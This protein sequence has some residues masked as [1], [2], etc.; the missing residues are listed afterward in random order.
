MF[1]SVPAAIKFVRF[2]CQSAGHCLTNFMYSDICNNQNDFQPCTPRMTERRVWGTKISGYQNNSNNQ[3]FIHSWWLGISSAVP[4]IPLH[5]YRHFKTLHYKDVKN[6]M[7]QNKSQDLKSKLKNLYVFRVD[8]YL[9][10]WLTSVWS[11]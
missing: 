7:A 8:F 9:Y 2:T 6:V 11:T 4:D 1:W 3:P 5:A 10:L